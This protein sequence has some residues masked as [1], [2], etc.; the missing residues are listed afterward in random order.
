[1]ND[2][3]RAGV[4][5]DLPNRGNTGY[6]GATVDPVACFRDQLAL[7]GGVLH[8]ASDAEKAAEVVIELLQARHAR[9]ILLGRGQVLDTLKLQPK[10]EPQGIQVTCVDALAGPGDRAALFGADAG[11]SGVAY[12]VAETGTV[13]A[14]SAPN[15]PRAL[16]LLPPLHIA[17]ADRSQLLED[18]FD[19]VPMLTAGGAPALPSCLTLITGPSKTGDIELKL[20]TGVHGPGEVHVVLITSRDREGAGM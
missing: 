18:F 7:A 16:T 19:L 2:G 3:N 20:V 13:V 10:L 8:L 12:L 9:K 1:V 17:V 6:Q 4:A 11:V 15:E 14:A 5:P